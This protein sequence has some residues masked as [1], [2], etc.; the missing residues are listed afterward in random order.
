L[1]GT[2]TIMLVEDDDAVQ[3]FGA[4]ALR[5][6]G[7]RVIEAKSGEVALELIRNAEYRIDLLITDVVMPQMDGPALIREVRNVAPDLKVIFISGYTEDAFRQRLDSE[8]DIH[9]LP[10]PFS[11][12]QLAVKVK[13]VLTDDLERSQFRDCVRPNK[14]GTLSTSA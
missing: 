5:N 13:D 8:R 2:G 12:K 11:L 14:I 1:T 3:M 10:K 9:F 4:R 7:Y 6:K